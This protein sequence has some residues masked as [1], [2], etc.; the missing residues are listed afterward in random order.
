MDYSELVDRAIEAREKAYAP[1][2]EFLVGAALLCKDGT[3]YTG[4]NIENASYGATNCAERTA[5]FK[6]VSEGAGD[7]RAIAIVGARQGEAL[8]Y[9][10]PC[11]I[12]RQVMTEFCDLDAFKIILSDGENERVYTLRDMIPY[13]FDNLDRG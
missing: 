4:C 2:S 6:A 5:I 9:C 13:S 8:D 1:Y 12:C 11:G 3:V 10:P 7:F